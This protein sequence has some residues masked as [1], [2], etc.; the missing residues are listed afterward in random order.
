MKNPEARHRGEDSTSSTDCLRLEYEEYL[1][2]QRGLSERTIHH[3][4][5]LADR[6]LQ[7]R[8]NG[9]SRDLSTI[10]CD[11]IA[12]FMQHLTSGRKPFRDKTP[13]THLRNFFRFLF[14]S[15]KINANLALGVPRIA[16]R[17]AS[18]MPRYLAPE[19]VEAL[20]AAVKVDSA[21]GRRN[22]AI[23]LLLAR[24]GLRATEVI[25]VQI[26]DIDWR[27]ELLIRGKGQLHDRLPLPHDVGAALA[28]YI[29]RGRTTSSRALVCFAS[30]AKGTIRRCADCQR[31]SEG[32]VQKDQAGA[33]VTIC[34][35]ARS[36]TQSRNQHGTAGRI[37]SGD[38]RCPSAPYAKHDDDL[39]ETRC[40]GAAFNRSAWP[41]VGAQ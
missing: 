26:D 31:Y 16:Q 25:A 32:S 21:I 7:F 10:S 15:G 9:D 34:R 27:G 13:P 20:I 30:G 29:Q 37:V 5:R 6:F 3:C 11:D 24:L 28:D 12:R 33:A 4:W 19:Q 8:F 23:I 35:V 39:R 22:Y 38:R 40:R 41:V 18:R 36:L 14:M 2:N 1:R 17:Y